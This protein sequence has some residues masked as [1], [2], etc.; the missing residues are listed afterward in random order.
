MFHMCLK[1]VLTGGK[2]MLHLFEICTILRFYDSFDV[3]FGCFA[4]DRKMSQLCLGNVVFFATI[5]SSDEIFLYKV[6]KQLSIC[7]CVPL[8]HT[9]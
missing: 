8:Y 9:H 2:T 1:K 6:T 3:C 7:R 5:L 4:D